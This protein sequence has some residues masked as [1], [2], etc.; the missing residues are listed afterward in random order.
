MHMHQSQG[1]AALYGRIINFLANFD[2]ID[3]LTPLMTFDPDEKK[4]TCT[5]TKC[6]VPV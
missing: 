1:H 5:Q 6:I 4:Y 2:K 3:L